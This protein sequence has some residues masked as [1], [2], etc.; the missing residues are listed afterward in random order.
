MSIMNQRVDHATTATGPTEHLVPQTRVSEKETDVVLY[1]RGDQVSLHSTYTSRTTRTERNAL[2][3]IDALTTFQQE[4]RHEHIGRIV[5]LG[6]HSQ[7]EP[8]CHRCP[9]MIRPRLIIA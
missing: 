7:G 8:Q 4:S 6:V 5:R 3:Q 1:D 2:T 9:V